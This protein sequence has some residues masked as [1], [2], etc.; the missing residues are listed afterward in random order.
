MNDGQP[1]G[2]PSF[3]VR[4]PACS[5]LHAI[6]ELTQEDPEPLIKI[7]VWIS[8]ATPVVAHAE[9][10][11]EPGK[12]RWL[13]KE[14]HLACP[15]ATTVAH[16][17]LPVDLHS[18]RFCLVGIVRQLARS[19]ATCK[20]R[21]CVLGGMPAAFW[22]CQCLLCA[23]RKWCVMGVPLR[24]RML[25]CRSGKHGSKVSSKQRS[26]GIVPHDVAQVW[27]YRRSSGL[28]LPR[29]ATMMMLCACGVSSVVGGFIPSL[30]QRSVTTSAFH[31]VP[32]LVHKSHGVH[33]V[34]TAWGGQIISHAQMGWHPCPSVG[35]ITHAPM[36]G[37]IT[38]A[39]AMCLVTRTQQQS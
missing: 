13:F 15:V 36:W 16:S 25:V 33:H 35:C 28:C 19:L 37:G 21:M 23:T 20:R 10:L 8:V 18:A 17:Q 4:Q 32:S 9:A 31:G 3:P 34:C 27:R 14:P 38:S 2:A 24:R 30:L 7:R 6:A 5:L 29:N 11:P 39:H 12:G 1:A 22:R 26:A